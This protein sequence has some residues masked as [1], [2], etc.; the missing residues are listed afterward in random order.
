MFYFKIIAKKPQIKEDDKYMAK[1]SDKKTLIFTLLIFATMSIFTL[2]VLKSNV[3]ASDPHNINI[4]IINGEEG[5]NGWYT[6]DVSVKI[7]SDNPE[8]TEIAYEITGDGSVSKTTIDNEDIVNIT[9]EGINTI[10][11]YSKINEVEQ[12]DNTLEIKIDKSTPIGD[13]NSDNTPNTGNNLIPNSEFIGLNR[14]QWNICSIQSID[15]TKKYNGR[16]VLRL[17]TQSYQDIGGNYG[18]RT[19]GSYTIPNEKNTEYTLSFSVYIDNTYLP[20][21]NPANVNKKLKVV[22]QE[23]LSVGNRY[24]EIEVDAD[25]DLVYGQWKDFKLTFTT[26][27]NSYGFYALNVYFPNGIR[28]YGMRMWISNLKLEK[29]GT[30]TEYTSDNSKNWV[31]SGYI[32]EKN[33]VNDILSGLDY[34]S[35]TKKETNY[36]I[37]DMAGNEIDLGSCNANIDYTAPNVTVSGN[38][39]SSVEKNIN[40]KISDDESGFC[41]YKWGWSKSAAIEPGE[42]EWRNSEVSNISRT[43]VQPAGDWYLWIKAYDKVGN[44][45]LFIS[46]KYTFGTGIILKTENADLNNFVVGDSTYLYAYKNDGLVADVNWTSSNKNVLLVNSNGL[47]KAINPGTATITAK[48]TDNI[49]QSINMTIKRREVAHEIYVSP[50]G[51]DNNDGTIDRPY[52]TLNK[53]KEKARTY[54]TAS[55]QGDIDIYLRSG[56]YYI[57]EKFTLNSSDSG[58]NG[59]YINYMAYKNEKVVISG[60]TEV[61]NWEL[62]DAGKNIYRADVTNILSNATML[63]QLYVNNEKKQRARENIS[64]SEASKFSKVSGGYTVSDTSQ[65]AQKLSAAKNLQDIEFA[66]NYLWYHRRI[67]IDS[68]TDAGSSYNI[69]M[70]PGS[71]ADTNASDPKILFVKDILFIENAYEFLDESGEWYF[72]RTGAVSNESGKKYI[73]YKPEAGENINN[74]SVIVP[75]TEGLVNISGASSNTV[76]NIRIQ[77]LS[78]EYSTYAAR[79][80]EKGGVLGLQGNLYSNSESFTAAITFKYAK[81][82]TFE[83]NNLTRL[84]DVGISIAVGSKDIKIINNNFTNIAATAIQQ[85]VT[86]TNP[87]AA[88]AI[89]DL[90]VSNNIIDNVANEYYSGVG[91]TLLYTKNS[92]ID[93]NI[94]SNVPYT[95]INFGWGWNNSIKSINSNNKILFNYIYNVMTQLHDGG[96]IYCIGDQKGGNS[97]SNLLI[98]GNRLEPNSDK[99]KYFSGIYFDGG[100]NGIIFKDNI[101]DISG[102]DEFY[103]AVPSGEDGRLA[104]PYY[105]QLSLYGTYNHYGIHNYINFKPASDDFSPANRKFMINGTASTYDGNYPNYRAYNRQEIGFNAYEPTVHLKD[106]VSY[107]GKEMP[108][109]AKTVQRLATTSKVQMPLSVGVS[110]NNPEYNETAVVTLDTPIEDSDIYYTLDGSEPTVNSTKYQGNSTISTNKTNG[111]IIVIKAIAVKTGYNDSDVV[112]Q[113]ITFKA[114]SDANTVSITGVKLD[115]TKLTMITGNNATLIATVTPDNATNKAVTYSSDNTSVATVS[116]SGL[117]TAIGD[118]TAKI[119]VT[120][121]DGNFTAECDVTVSSNA[122]A[123]TGV[124][125]S[126]TSAT[127][128]VGQT[129]KLTPTVTPS[130]AIN[131]AVTYSSNNISVATVSESG[132]ITAVG[133]GTAKITITTTDGGYTA[134]YNVTVTKEVSSSSVSTGDI[135]YVML[136][137][138]V[139]ALSIIGVLSLLLWKNREYS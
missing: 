61:K 69:K 139:G 39:N 107:Y 52:L 106:N 49:Q 58:N 84:G 64:A 138:I 26:Q 57:N 28:P 88:D 79:I 14:W 29:G 127:L 50:N 3:I 62:Y 110:N 44:E 97:E 100:A 82:I 25:T 15:Q 83:N 135:N 78:F 104:I 30:V 48:T 5:N 46:D 43:A 72:D 87:S 40:I 89:T 38:A 91:I 4:I 92:I 128:K 112:S 118:G 71:W 31:T 90:T 108:A 54:N 7:Q 131:K 37:C 103:K 117:I 56:T 101:F 34:N 36:Y 120:T 66:Y 126:P 63:R 65:T 96:A 53:A 85:E 113:T 32:L 119:I 98:Q 130:N 114:K 99:S 94:I 95:G 51:N 8:I 22:L 13:F 111:D 132:L 109:A 12:L 6:S 86:S 80:K 55:M 75:R 23:V 27:S 116:E 93:H 73:Y 67:L 9:S 81:N 19:S 74:C 121:A 124:S 17:S 21:Q 11:V 35:F 42:Y 129:Q 134:T 115:K 59:Y 76:S 47:I 16:N 18:I 20:A 24:H 102:T 68:I 45:T 1:I 41:Y 60:E 2:F 10:N 133:V 122:I 33:G 70:D 137:I 105:V 77:G 123:V 136:W 125:V